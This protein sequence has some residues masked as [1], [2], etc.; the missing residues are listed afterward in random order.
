MLLEQLPRAARRTSCNRSQRDFD[1]AASRTRTRSW[2]LTLT[3]EGSTASSNISRASTCTEPAIA[4]RCFSRRSS[5]DGDAALTLFGLARGIACAR[6]RCRAAPSSRAVAACQRPPPQPANEPRRRLRCC[7]RRWCGA[8]GAGTWPGSS[9]RLTVVGG[10]A[11]VL[12]SR[13]APSS[14]G[15]WCRTSARA[16]PRACCL[17]S[18][19]PASAARS[20]WRRRLE[21]LA[22]LAGKPAEQF[23]LVANGEQSPARRA[24]RAARRIATCYHGRFDGA[25]LDETRLADGARRRAPR[26]MASPAGGIHR[27]A[28]CHAIP[29]SSCCR[30]RERWQPTFRTATASYDAWFDRPRAVARLLVVETHAAAFDPDR[31]RRVALE[32]LHAGVRSAPAA[33]PH[34]TLTVSGS[35][36]FSVP[37]SRTRT[38]ARSAPGSAR[39]PPLGLIVLMW[40]AYR[41]LGIILLGALPLAS[42]GLAGLGAVV[43]GFDGVHGI[44][45]AFG[46]TLIGVVQDYP[47]H[48]FSHQRA[49][50][51]RGRARARCGRRWPPASP[52]CIAYLTF[53]VSGVMASSSSRVHR[54]RPGDGALATR[55]LLPALIDPA[56]R[57]AADSPWL[58]RSWER[59]ARW[60]RLR[61]VAFGAR[62]GRVGRCRVRAGAV[63]AE[64]PGRL[65]PVPPRRWRATQLRGELGAPDVRYVIALQ[66]PTRGGAARLRAPAAGIAALG[67]RRRHRVAT[68]SPRVTCPAPRRSGAPGPIARPR[69]VAAGSTRR[70]PSD[71]SSATHS[72]HSSPMSNARGG[73]RHCRARPARHATRRQRRRTAVWS[74]TAT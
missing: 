15:C 48:L 61:W 24:R 50:R 31:A 18:R 19:W 10:P 20:S 9:S 36:Y 38:R 2:T 3:P 51:R 40:I 16:R 21:Q 35:G 54:G 6:D 62:R 64:R 27:G 72:S 52:T 65:T 30:W 37:S 1:V 29:R 63:L 25:P 41:R 32:A 59:L 42:G 70:R 22:G 23:E 56:P 4:R 44:T 43:L 34:A 12:A 66:R 46:F 74:A 11:L 58:G 33:N 73:R 53:L 45:V 14:S 68:T 5:A 47:I 28:G 69:H 17:S 8:A 71:R 67:G 57:D 13:H 49:G 26:I 39:P 7:S 60:P 55:F